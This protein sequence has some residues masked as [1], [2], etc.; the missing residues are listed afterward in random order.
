MILVFY[1]AALLQAGLFPWTLTI[2]KRLEAANLTVKSVDVML[3]MRM[4]ALSS[5]PSVLKNSALGFLRT[6]KI[7][8]TKK[9]STK[10]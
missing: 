2:Q 6:S 10:Y 1:V 4:S 9:G 8:L 5:K 3:S 7:I